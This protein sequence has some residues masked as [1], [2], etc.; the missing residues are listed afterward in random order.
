MHPSQYSQSLPLIP[1][2]IP[3]PK[4]NRAI[5]FNP[6]RSLPVLSALL[7]LCLVTPSTHLS[8]QTFT[9]PKVS[10][11]GAPSYS[12]AELLAFTG[13][14]PGTKSTSA[15]VQSAAQRLSDTGLFADVHFESNANGL[16]YT[17][18]LMPADNLLPARFANLIWWSPEELNTALKAR[19]PLYLGLV[20]ISGNLQDSVSA[21]LKTMLA[22][23]NVTATITTSPFV[24]QLG[25]PPTAISFNIESPEIRVHNLTL[26][27]ASP[28]MQ[29]KLDKVVKENLGKPFDQN[30]TRAAITTQINE[31]YRN[32][33]YLD[34][35]L[36][37]LTHTAPQITP[38]GIDLD[39][40]ATLSEGEPYRLSYLTWSGSDIMS[41]ADFNK[42]VKLKPED[43]ASQLAL[44][45][46]LA[47]LA[48]A[49]SAKGF[50]DARVQAPATI[51]H[52]THH[53]SYTIRVIPGEQ[54]HLHSVKAVGLSDEQQKQFNS[55]WHLNPGD[56]FDATY[57]T[58]F[59]KKN[60]ALR[61]FE[62]YSAN[63]RAVADPN[64]H[65]VDL[66]LTFVK[67]GVLN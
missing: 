52:A 58:S 66:T 21:A 28:A 18:K 15:E 46:S 55:G 67:G 60:T 61:T 51:D 40:T 7:A 50:Q 5:P 23:K 22:E 36:L 24:P 27:Q 57:V 33:G 4:T 56:I 54:Y 39:L 48:N 42:S 59:L 11:T 25:A 49:Y 19:V 34:I 30:A 16:V 35:D 10:F 63:Y 13:L 62:G 31:I 38:T 65:L 37:D 12:Q 6:M 43:I 41:T 17:L 1:S 44:R 32:D 47:P 53:V 29:P 64:T 3:S 26:A 45:Q 14:K 2:N 8:A 20:P 9:L